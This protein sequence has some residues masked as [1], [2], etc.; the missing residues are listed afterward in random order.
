MKI[1]KKVNRKEKLLN[2]NS[3][4][5]KTSNSK[6]N[7]FNYLLKKNIELKFKNALTI[8][9]GFHSKNKKILFLGTP[10]KLNKPLKKLFK[11]TNHSFIPEK[12]WL[13]GV[14]SNT[15]SVL[16]FLFKKYLK[17]NKNNLKFLFK[18]TS[19]NNLIVILNESLSTNPLKEFYKKKIPTISLNC[20]NTNLNCSN[21][22]YRIKQNLNDNENKSINNLF[23][24][25]LV[26]TLKKAEI[27]RKAHVKAVK[28]RIEFQSKLRLALQ[29]R[30][31]FEAKLRLSRGKKNKFSSNKKRVRQKNKKIKKKNAFF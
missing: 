6:K 27:K 4:Q 8:I 22:T 3:L 9:F 30:K 21:S 31:K 11:N 14:L 7:H 5:I 18:L 25:V 29:R 26:A 10:L 17:K 20:S 19:K 28:A 15:K 2:L 13:N 12:I 16:K 1:V 23:F 24:S